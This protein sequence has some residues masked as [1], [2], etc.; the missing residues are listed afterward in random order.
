VG[1][2][3]V[4]HEEQHVAL[5]GREVVE[6]R[7]KSGGLGPVGAGRR[8]HVLGRVQRRDRDGG[9]LGPGP[10]RPGAQAVDG[11]VSGDADQPAA[12]APAPRVEARGVAPE[13]E[14]RLLADV[15]G[16]AGAVQ[17]GQ[18]VGV[19]R[20]RVALV[21]GLEGRGVAVGHPR[22]QGGLVRRRL[23]LA[24]GWSGSGHPP[25]LIRAGGDP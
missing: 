10:A 18:D 19:H 14:E 25:L 3:A 8:D 15:L 20:P 24:V 5:L 16:L 22:H 12:H 13:G 7:P 6:Q 23:G 1:E 2:A 21:D 11:L 9:G 4:V 17:L